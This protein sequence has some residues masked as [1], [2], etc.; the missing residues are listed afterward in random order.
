MV[1]NL[2]EDDN[3]KSLQQ[4]RRTTDKSW[5]EKLTWAF[6]SGKLKKVFD[7]FW[8]VFIGPVIMPVDS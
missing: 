4:Q 7:M 3:V 5:S 8:N 6:G 2:E 1:L